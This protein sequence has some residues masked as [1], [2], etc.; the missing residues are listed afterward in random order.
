MPGRVGLYE[1]KV[2]IPQDTQ[3]GD[4]VPLYLTNGAWHSDTAFM[5]VQ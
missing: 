4:A 3:T 5:A 2:T 1:I